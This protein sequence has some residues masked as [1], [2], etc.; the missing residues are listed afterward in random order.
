MIN[1]SYFYSFKPDDW[2]GM[3][4]TRRGAGLVQGVLAHRA[5]VLSE[6]LPN[7]GTA[8]NPMDMSMYRFMYSSCRV[9]WPGEDLYI[10]HE[11]A[12]YNHFIVMRRGRVF[13]VDAADTSGTPHTTARLERQLR[14]VVRLADS[15]AQAN[16][17]VDAGVGIL[18]TWHRDSW[19]E[20]RAHLLAAGDGTNQQSLEKIETAFMVLCLDHEAPADGEQRARAAW[21][22]DGHNRWFDKPLQFVVQRL[23]PKQ[24]QRPQ[25]ASVQHGQVSH[26]RV[27]LRGRVG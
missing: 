14:E 12:A 20:A 6:Q 21:H 15:E 10:T 24:P 18:T 1:V 17:C 13:T 5:L 2:S 26:R 16:V 8:D 9:A 27:M 19:A 4:Q 11:P 7:E 23:W 25:L 3:V 22:G